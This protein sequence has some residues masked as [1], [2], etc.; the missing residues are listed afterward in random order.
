MKKLGLLFVLMLCCVALLC[1][2]SKKEEKKYDYDLSE[3]I[4]LGDFPNVK[5]DEEELQELIDESVDTIVADYV[6]TKEITD[7]GVIEGD[8]VNIDYEGKINGETFEGGS[9]T[10]S[11]LVIGSDSFI[12]GFED[13]LIDKKTGDKVTLNLKFP[14]D[15]QSADVAGKDVEFAVTI[16]KI[17]TKF[18]PSITDEMVKEKTDFENVDDY[19]KSEREKYAENIIWE[20]YKKSCKVLKYPE[21]EVKEYYDQMVESYSSM[22]V[23]YGMTLQDIV[24]MYFGYTNID[25]FL[26]YVMT[27]AMTSVKEE[28]V[29]YYTI[30][31]YEELDVDEDKYEEIGLELAK[32]AGYTTLKEYE[33]YIGEENVKH[34][35]RM[36]NIIEKALE[37]N[38]ILEKDIKDYIPK[39]DDAAETESKPETN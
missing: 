19:I 25:D 37:A 28:M 1:S 36:D 13:G 31:K 3:Y 21:A 8:T 26:S 15:Y 14:D 12:A 39:G 27:S 35:I 10:G 24:S 16:N 7:R 6:T 9:A 29:I 18:T 38:G 11:D 4:T 22:A 20:Q 33:E 2:C 17:T 32:E 34:Q 23:S 30:E 5:L